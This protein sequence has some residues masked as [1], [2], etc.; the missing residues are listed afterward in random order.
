[1]DS[2]RPNIHDAVEMEV[3]ETKHKYGTCKEYS[4]A[5]LQVRML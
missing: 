3:N 4:E 5:N 1:M 2:R